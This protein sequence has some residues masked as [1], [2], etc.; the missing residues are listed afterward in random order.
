MRE[1]I[2]LKSLFL[3]CFFEQDD[4]FTM[5]TSGFTSVNLESILSKK[6]EINKLE[7]TIDE[8]KED[9]K[10]Y[11]VNKNRIKKSYSF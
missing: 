3:D 11:Y 5:M 6:F 10:L 7:Y 1:H 8:I 2:S 9:Y 4:N